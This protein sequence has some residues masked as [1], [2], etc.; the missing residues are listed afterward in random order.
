MLI[1]K[2]P[3]VS[4]P[5]QFKL[6]LF[7]MVVQSMVLVWSSCKVKTVKGKILFICNLASFS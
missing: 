3:H 7:K 6:V 5:T 4:E 2:H 1:E